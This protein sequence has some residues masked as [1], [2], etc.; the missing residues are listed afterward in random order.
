MVCVC[1]DSGG[2]I[3]IFTFSVGT[4]RTDSSSAHEVASLA[5]GTGTS[6]LSAGLTTTCAGNWTS[7]GSGEH[8]LVDGTTGWAEGASLWGSGIESVSRLAFVTGRVG[9]GVN[10]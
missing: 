1:N 6:S 10:T 7:F 2:R 9:V 8:V 3:S 5:G 4:E